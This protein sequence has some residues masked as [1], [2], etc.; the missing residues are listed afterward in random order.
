ML[1]SKPEFY[2]ICFSLYEKLRVFR[3]AIIH[4]NSFQSTQNEL[5]IN[6][7]NGQTITFSAKELFAFGYSVVKISEFLQGEELSEKSMRDLEGHLD[8]LNTKHKRNRFGVKPPSD[9]VVIQSIDGSRNDIT[10]KF[11]WQVDIG[12]VWKKFKSTFPKTEDFEF[13]LHGK[14]PDGAELVLVIPSWHLPQSGLLQ[15]SEDDKKGNEFKV[16]GIADTK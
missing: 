9:V 14:Q 8:M 13:E 1:I 2:D 7:K 12:E 5:K 3:N 16:I 15:I 11:E 4:N 6:D 10:G